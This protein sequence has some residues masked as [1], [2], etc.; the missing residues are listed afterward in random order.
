MSALALKSN[1]PSGSSLLLAATGLVWLPQP[2]APASRVDPPLAHWVG[3]GGSTA[4]S[5]S[6]RVAPV[7]PQSVSLLWPARVG[8]RLSQ[9]PAR[10]QLP[11]TLSGERFALRRR[12]T[13]AFSSKWQRR[14]DQPAVVR[15]LL[16][17]QPHRDRS[18]NAPGFTRC[19]GHGPQAPV[20]MDRLLTRCRAQTTTR[21]TRTDD[22]TLLSHPGYSRARSWAGCRQR[23][24]FGVLGRHAVRLRLPEPRVS[25]RPAG[26]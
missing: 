13:R 12:I 6:C 18:Q 20:Q 5:F 19:S 23:R 21:S 16:G 25:P 11:D 1:R 2:L 24:D 7:P 9:A 4:A 15:Y 3:R 17:A 10:P 8:A 14:D 26:Q 22:P